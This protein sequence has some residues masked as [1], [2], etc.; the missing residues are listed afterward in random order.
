MNQIS[1]ALA[2]AGIK[3][4]PLNERVWNCLRDS[5]LP[6]TG[7]VI[8]QMLNVKPADVS[9]VLSNMVKRGMV[10]VDYQPESVKVGRGYARREVGHYTAVGTHYELRPIPLKPAAVAPVVVH[11]TP[12]TVDIEK[13]TLSEAHILYKRLKEFFA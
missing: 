1:S 11:P 5:K 2:Q 9:G 8:S 7:K 10:S 12:V 13:M 4:P 3:M 6:R